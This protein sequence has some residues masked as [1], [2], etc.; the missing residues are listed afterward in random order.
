MGSL[1]F[2]KQSSVCFYMIVIYD[3]PCPKKAFCL[4]IKRRK[5]D[6]VTA[7]D[8]FCV[9]DDVNFEMHHP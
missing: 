2:T 7:T 4:R 9:H 1:D 8:H 6:S 3:Q 5:K